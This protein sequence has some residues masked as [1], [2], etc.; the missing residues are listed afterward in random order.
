VFGCKTGKSQEFEVR[1][2]LI[3]IL[4]EVGP[5]AYFPPKLAWRNASHRNSRGFGRINSCVPK[6]LIW[7]IP[8]G[9]ESYEIPMFFLHSKG[10]LK[11]DRLLGILQEVGPLAYFPPKLAWRNAS[12][13][14]SRGFGW[15]N[16]CVPKF[17]RLSYEKFL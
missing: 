12:H 9:I 2:R 6:A 16:S 13:R 14:N 8:A 4:Q 7:K 11:W 1:D 5:L 15:I 17:Q 3:G 10:S